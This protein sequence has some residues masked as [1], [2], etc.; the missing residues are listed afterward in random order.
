MR[1]DLERA[2]DRHHHG[3]RR[4]HFDDAPLAKHCTAAVGAS[5][6]SGSVGI[7]MPSSVAGRREHPRGTDSP[8][9]NPVRRVHD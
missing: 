6:V 7:S 4:R 2:S 8:G 9:P 3:R 1:R 5:E